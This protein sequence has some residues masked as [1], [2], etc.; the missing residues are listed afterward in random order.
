MSEIIFSKC[1]N[2]F[3]NYNKFIGIGCN[4]LALNNILLLFIY[5]HEGN[6]LSQYSI[7]NLSGCRSNLENFAP[8]FGR[9]LESL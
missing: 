1:G 5:L 2:K 9:F 7:Y 3:A 4:R 8:K 6:F